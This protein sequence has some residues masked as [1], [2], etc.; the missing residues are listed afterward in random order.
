MIVFVPLGAAE[1]VVKSAVS[2]Q[3]ELLIPNKWNRSPT[4]PPV[5]A[6]LLSSEKDVA[7]L[8]SAIWVSVLSA[9]VE[10]KVTLPLILVETTFVVKVI[11]VALEDVKTTVI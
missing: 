9:V 10:F 3:S 8:A 11:A 6:A 2:I 4:P 7:V 1:V 5:P